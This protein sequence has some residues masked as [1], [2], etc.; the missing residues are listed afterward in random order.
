MNVNIKSNNDSKENIINSSKNELL[1]SKNDYI[2][3][4]KPNEINKYLEETYKEKEKMNIN[5]E[6][7]KKQEIKIEYPGPDKN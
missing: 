5:D 1:D 2:N 6:I 3:F 4:S 7:N